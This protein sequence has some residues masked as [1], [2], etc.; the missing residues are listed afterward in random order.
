[1]SNIMFVND[2]HINLYKFVSMG[3]S[4]IK[5]MSNKKYI[6]C[7]IQTRG[8]RIEM[9]PFYRLNLKSYP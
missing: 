4:L 8:L 2:F 5:F 6:M 3:F 1:M 9:Q 7:A